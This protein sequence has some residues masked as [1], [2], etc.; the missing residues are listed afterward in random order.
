MCSQDVP[1]SPDPSSGRA[2]TVDSG[3]FE[4]RDRA[5]HGLIETLVRHRPVGE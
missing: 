4:V 1:S 3:L 2:L 5:F